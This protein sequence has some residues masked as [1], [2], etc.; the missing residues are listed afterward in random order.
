MCYYVVAF[1]VN[2]CLATLDTLRI[3]SSLEYDILD[4]YL[5]LVLVLIV[6]WSL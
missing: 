6:F 4:L 3:Q 1:G 2:C 5:D